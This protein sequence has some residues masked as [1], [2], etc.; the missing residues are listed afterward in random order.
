[1]EKFFFFD[2]LFAINNFAVDQSNLASWAAEG[3]KADAGEG[4][5]CV[6]KTG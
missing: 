5:G 6:L 2:P 4:F 1:M 3:E